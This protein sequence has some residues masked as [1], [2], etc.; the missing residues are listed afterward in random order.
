LGAIKTKKKQK[1]IK[2]KYTSSKM[3]QSK[4]GGWADS[5][6]LQFNRFHELVNIARKKKTSRNLE[7]KI[8]QVL[9]ERNN[10]VCDTDEDQQKWNRAARRRAAKGEAP[11][12]VGEVHVPI[13]NHPKIEAAVDEPWEEESSSEDEEEEKNDNGQ[14]DED[15]EDSD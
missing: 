7:N 3:G 13:A 2:G 1:L 14:D 4:W 6:I 5:G 10:I 12:A 11:P 15:E 8:L 9:R